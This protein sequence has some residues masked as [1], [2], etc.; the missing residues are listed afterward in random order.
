MEGTCTSEV[1]TR[2]MGLSPGARGAV[3]PVPGGATGWT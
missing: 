2:V 3:W 1:A